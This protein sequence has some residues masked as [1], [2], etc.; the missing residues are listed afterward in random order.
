MN[1][2]FLVFGEYEGNEEDDE[3][4]MGDNDRDDLDTSNN[5]KVLDIMLDNFDGEG[6]GANKYKYPNKDGDYRRDDQGQK[7]HNKNNGMDEGNRR[8]RKKYE[9]NRK[10]RPEKSKS[11][12][13]NS[14]KTSN[15][16]NF[17]C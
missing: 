1:Y 9:N 12:Y 6:N 7:R 11:I 2:F 5:R 4:D 15:F 14:S 3:D 8:R 16:F 17:F 13:G 10:R